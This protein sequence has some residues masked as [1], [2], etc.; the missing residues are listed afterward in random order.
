[1]IQFDPVTGRVAEALPTIKL[2][3]NG[4]LST[5]DRVKIGATTAPRTRWELGHSSDGWDKMVVVYSSPFAGS[6][7]SME[8]ALITHAR[9]TRYRV[10]RANVLPG[11][12]SIYDGYEAYYVYVLMAFGS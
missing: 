8:R 4:V 10:E 2:R 5:Y 7:R 9:G 11:G 12:E 1:M 3:L 6:T